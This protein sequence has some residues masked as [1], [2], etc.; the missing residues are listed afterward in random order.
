MISNRGPLNIAYADGFPCLKY[1]KSKRVL[2]QNGLQAEC[3]K[4]HGLR[5]REQEHGLLAHAQLEE[6]LVILLIPRLHG[7]KVWDRD[8]DHTPEPQLNVPCKHLIAIPDLDRNPN[9][10]KMCLVNTS[11]IM[12]PIEIL[13]ACKVNTNAIVFVVFLSS[14]TMHN[15]CEWID[16]D[17][18]PFSFHARVNE[19]RC[20]RDPVFLLRVNG[21][22]EETLVFGLFWQQ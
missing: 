1:I 15:M 4:S 17:P 13:Y 5:S 14:V 2:T 21:V 9:P 12:I 19:T 18:D 22:K 7:A 16:C 10:E 20:N 3:R 11:R 8:P 6:A